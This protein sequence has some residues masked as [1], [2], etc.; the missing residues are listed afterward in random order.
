MAAP[1]I[2]TDLS[3]VTLNE[4]NTG[5]SEASGHT[6]GGADATDS[7]TYIQGTAAVSQSTGQ[8]TGTQA[9]LEYDYGSDLGTGWTSGEVF[10]AWQYFSSPTNIQTF[11]NGGMRFGIGSSSGNIDWYNTMGDDFGT[12]PYGGWQNTAVDPEYSTADLTDG[13]PTSGVY[14]IFGSLPNLRA[15]ITKGSPHVVDAIRYGRAEI[16]VTD[17]DLSN[18]YA[19]F[20][21]MAQENDYN[22]GTNGYNRWGLFQEVQG[23]YLWKG[24][25]SLGSTSAVDFRDSNR[26]ISIADTPRTYAAFNKIEIN[27]ASSR[28]DWT[29]ISISALNESGLSRGAFEVVDNADVN[30][31]GCT[32][33]GM[34][35]FSF[36]A[37]SAVLNTT[38]RRCNAVTVTTGSIVGSTFDSSTV[39]ADGAALIYN[40]TQNPDGYFDDTSFTKG[41]NDHHAIEFGTSAPTT[42]TLRGIDFSGFS[43]TA[44]AAT[45]NFLRTSGTTTVNL[46][47]CSGTITAKVTGTHTVTFVTNP[48]TVDVHVQDINT[49]SAIQ[50]ARVYLLAATTGPL[51]FEDTVTITSTGGVATVSHTGHGLATNQWV[52]I[53]GADQEEYNGAKQIT[54]TGVDA[55]TY[56]VT[57]TPTSPATGTI[58]ATAIIIFGTTD[59]NGDIS[60]SRSYAS[61]QDFTGR[62]RYSSNPYYK[63]SP[64]T[65]TIDNINGLP[66]TVSLIPDE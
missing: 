34:N 54:V 65:G 56:A 49:G 28:I 63:A 32:F 6:T 22:D 1:S 38:F 7:E 39:A 62:V 53:E 37:N 41:T 3:T 47:G 17:G 59:V 31:D 58:N 21:V 60:D 14:Q 16:I 50:G 11:A 45:L 46:V 25:M 13:S 36:L 19:T 43:G 9:G 57:G 26:V 30:F 18:G 24:L 48:V 55:Y 27:N 10:L 51:P 5:W 40:Q 52:K 4:S 23:G 66:I 42:I 61:D 64:L 29:N 20:V 44:N 8:A 2:T 12:Y 35:T 15:K 33:T